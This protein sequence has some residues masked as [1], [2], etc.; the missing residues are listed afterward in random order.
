M[1]EESKE[2]DPAVDEAA[3]KEVVD[4]EHTAAANED[5]VEEDEEHENT[6]TDPVATGAATKKKK[7]KKAKIKKALGVGAKG[8]A[9][10]S[11]SSKPASKLT[12]AQVDQLLEM[13]PS[14]KSEIAGLDKEKAT[15]KLKKMD[16]ADLLTGMVCEPRAMDTTRRS[17]DV[18]TVCG[19]EEPERH[20]LIQVLANSA[21]TSIWSVGRHFD[22]LL[23]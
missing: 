13:N 8:D 3:I 21:C 14:L 1:T 19:R 22:G 10:A 23:S 9:E 4:S 17:T 18:Q 6:S 5:E 7:S 11:S 2:I 12:Q 16:V 20:G 15:E